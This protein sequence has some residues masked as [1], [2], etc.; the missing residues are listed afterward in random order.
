[1]RAALEEMRDGATGQIISCEGDV[2]D[3]AL[4]NTL[5]ALLDRSGLVLGLLVNNAGVGV[6]GRVDETDDAALTALLD[7]NVTAIFRLSRFAVTEMGASGGAI[8]NVASI[9]AEI[10]AA[11]AAAYSVTKGAVTALTRQM[12]TDFGPQGI[13]VNAVAPGVI[14]TP[15]IVERLRTE[16]FRRQVSVDHCPL[17]R[18]GQPEEVASVIAFLGSEA[19]SFVTGE[20]IRID[21]G[22]AVGRFP[23]ED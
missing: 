2:T 10:G 12:A 11:S 17:R 9:Y 23:R 8:V 14:E 16:A 5:R 1:S 3:P 7:V 19:A 22:W 18:A 13:R 15:M 6:R 20:T 4:P 21:G